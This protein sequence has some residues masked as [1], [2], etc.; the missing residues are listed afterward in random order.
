MKEYDRRWK[1][2]V[3][4]ESGLR[5]LLDERTFLP[6]TGWEKGVVHYEFN[7]E[8]LKAELEDAGFSIMDMRNIGQHVLVNCRKRG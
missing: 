8:I 6:I 7:K 4:T 3:G 1:E 5:T 2:Q